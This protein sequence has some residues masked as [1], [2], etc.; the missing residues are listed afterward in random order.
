MTEFDIIVQGTPNPHAAKFVLERP[1]LG[2][3]S[4]SYFAAED[5]TGDSLIVP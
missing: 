4:R 5:A 2:T 3:G 1:A